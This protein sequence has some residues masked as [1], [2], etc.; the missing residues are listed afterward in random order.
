MW[1]YLKGTEWNKGQFREL[2]TIP[3]FI[4]RVAV[5]DSNHRP[6]NLRVLITE[7]IKSAIVILSKWAQIQ[8]K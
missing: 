1:Q 7:V 4:Q 8:F 3:M 6:T 2:C 5:C